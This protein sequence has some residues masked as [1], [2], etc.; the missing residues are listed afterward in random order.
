M[1]NLGNMFKLFTTLLSAALIFTPQ[2]QV[3]NA[4]LGY[5]FTVPAGFVPFPEGKGAGPDV[6]D[7]WAEERPTPGY[8]AVVLCVQRMR[9]LIPR[10][11]M[12]AEELPAGSEMM[13]LRWKELDI[14]GIRTRTTQEGRQVLALVAQVPMKPEAIHIVLGGSAGRESRIRMMLNEVLAS[15]D[16]ES[17]WLTSTERAERGGRAFGVWV[18]LAVVLFVVVMARKR[19]AARL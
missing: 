13:P 16:G 4:E 6:V 7:C 14:Q 19:R 12:K 10:D 1:T 11:A 3:T 17:S 15:L 9:T 8:D 2:A 5:R 18:G